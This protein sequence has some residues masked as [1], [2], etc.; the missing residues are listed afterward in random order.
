MFARGSLRHGS[1]L[2]AFK[3][4]SKEIDTNFDFESFIT[5]LPN[6][7][8]VLSSLKPKPA[9]N[10][11]GAATR[12][13]YHSINVTQNEAELLQIRANSRLDPRLMDKFNRMSDNS[14]NQLGS[15][16]I[17]QP[18]RYFKTRGLSLRFENNTPLMNSGVY[19]VP[20]VIHN[21]EGDDNL[22]DIYAEKQQKHAEKF[23]E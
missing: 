2:S 6:K 22:V 19:A 9:N 5:K 18:G 16:S 4:R 17:F 7:T 8:S 10:I 1:I 15:M 20:T 23:I 3:G 21:I 14:L 11:V 13:R 12:R